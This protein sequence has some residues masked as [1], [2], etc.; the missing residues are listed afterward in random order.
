MKEKLLYVFRILYVLWTF[1]YVYDLLD[2]LHTSGNIEL[3]S[4]FNTVFLCYG[5][6]Y[7]FKY[8]SK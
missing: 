2:K 5:I 8:Y 6:F 1:F 7:M 4:I 3:V